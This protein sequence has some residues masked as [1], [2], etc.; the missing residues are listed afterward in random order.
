MARETNPA[1]A[2]T[3]LALLTALAAVPRVVANSLTGF[4]VSGTGGTENL[5]G[6][7][8]GLAAALGWLGFPEQGLGWT[9]FFLL[10]GAMAVPGMLLLF[11]VAPFSEAQP[12]DLQSASG[13]AS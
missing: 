2:A 6:M 9:N 8:A 10:C 11:W 5:S 13:D 1:L 12:S 3:Q 7:A 4:L